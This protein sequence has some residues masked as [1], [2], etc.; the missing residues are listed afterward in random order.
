MIYKRG[1]HIEPKGFFVVEISSVMN[2]LYIAAYSAVGP[3]SFVIFF[4]DQEARDIL[5]KFGTDFNIMAMCLM[6]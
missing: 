1:H 2:S 4:K 5:H 6:F 3:E